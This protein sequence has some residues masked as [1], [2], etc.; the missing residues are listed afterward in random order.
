M[1]PRKRVALIVRMVTHIN[2]MR[3]LNRSALLALACVGLTACGQA[4]RAA[5]LSSPL[6]APALDYTTAARTPQTIVLA[7]GCFWGVEGVFEHVKGV[8]RAVAGY[9]GGTASTADYETVSTG[10]TGHAESVAVTYDPAQITLGQLLQVY[11]S[12]VQD[13]ITLNAQGPDHGT[14]Y[15]SEIFVA[16]TRQRQIATA[17]I[18]QLDAAHIFGEPIVT[19]VGELQGFYPAE[20]YHQHYMALNPHNPYIRINDAPKVAALQVNFPALYRD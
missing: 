18:K 3:H 10:T 16:D 17:Y 7:G 20:G 11:F 6:P 12:V 14:Q 4:S 1:M 2:G 8:T 15:R 9:A 5:T 19:T 13:P